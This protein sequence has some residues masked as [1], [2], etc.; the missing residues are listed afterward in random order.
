VLVVNHDAV[1][2][3]LDIEKVN[4]AELNHFTLENGEKLPKL[5]DLKRGW[6]DRAVE[7][8]EA[9]RPFTRRQRYAPKLATAKTTPNNWPVPK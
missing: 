9:A 2:H 4:Y 1:Y 8:A 5:R 6:R 3:G 7:T